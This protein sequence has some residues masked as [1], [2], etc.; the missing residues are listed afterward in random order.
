MSNTIQSNRSVFKQPHSLNRRYILPSAPAIDIHA[1]FMSTWPFGLSRFSLFAKYPTALLISL[2]LESCR[3]HIA[4]AYIE[5]QIYHHRKHVE[6][7][8]FFGVIQNTTM[9]VFKYGANIFWKRRKVGSIILTKGEA[10]VDIVACVT[11]FSP[12][13]VYISTKI[14]LSDVSFYGYMH[15]CVYLLEVVAKTNSLWLGSP[16]QNTH[17]VWDDDGRTFTVFTH[18]F[19]YVKYSPE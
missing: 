16:S 6:L 15:K 8:G 13:P 1:P 14:L 5:W 17:T 3:R 10:V 11:V 9:V 19:I 12:R 2:E 7:S 4:S 18:N